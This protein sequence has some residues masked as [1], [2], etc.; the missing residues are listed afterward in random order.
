M[1]ESTTGR[2]RTPFIYDAVVAA[3]NRAPRRGPT[4]HLDIG[5]GR[6]ELINK[7]ASAL[8]GI[9]SFACD[10]HVERFAGRG[11]CTR[12]QRDSEP[13]PYAERRF[14]LVTCSEVVEHLENYRR[15]VRE[16]YR[17]TAPGAPFIVMG[18]PV[19]WWFE[20]FRYKTLR[21]G[22]TQF[23]RAQIS[24]KILLWRTIVVSAVR[25]R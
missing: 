8:P 24:M 18:W 20:R 11:E 6:G 22:S 21:E 25:A 1:A 15:L 7:L 4:A 23:V 5:A 16:A 13:L 14:D 12:V 10:F 2:I 17:V 3:A 19:F 9:E